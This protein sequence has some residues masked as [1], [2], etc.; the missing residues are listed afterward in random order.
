VSFLEKGLAFWFILEKG[1]AFA[2]PFSRMNQNAKPFSKNLWFYYSF[3]TRAAIATLLKEN[4]CRLKV[5]P[6]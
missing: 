3:W 2:E 6:L 5:R 1:L 4:A